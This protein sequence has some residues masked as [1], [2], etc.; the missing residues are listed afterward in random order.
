MSQVKKISVAGVYGKIKLTDLI[1][2]KSFD[3]MQVVGCAVG[4]RTG[5]TSFGEFTAL[6]GTFA[7]TH[8]ETGEVSQAAVLYIPDVALLPILTALASPD[9]KGVDFA[10]MV[11]VKYVADDAGYKTGG[12][13][14]EYTFRHLLDMG[15]DDPI[16]RI[17]AKIAAQTAAKALPAPVPEAKQEVAPAKKGK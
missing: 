4:K 15:S 1:A 14:Y 8:P 16:A 5:V 9:A 10:I 2:K 12:S 3:V 13:V 17:N 7:A 11:S 6:Q